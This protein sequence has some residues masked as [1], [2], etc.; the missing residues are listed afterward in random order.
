[1]IQDPL[2]RTQVAALYKE[3]WDVKEIAEELGLPLA[4]VIEYCNKLV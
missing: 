4:D 2:I 1:M 3:G